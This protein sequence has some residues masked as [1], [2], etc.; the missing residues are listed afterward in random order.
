MIQLGNI[1]RWLALLV[2]VWQGSHPR[3]KLHRECRS[4]AQ[5]IM[6]QV[7]AVEA[8]FAES[9]IYRKMI[10]YMV[11]DLWLGLQV[12]RLHGV[13][14]N[15]ADR[16]RYALSAPV[17]AASLAFTPCKRWTCRPNHRSSTMYQN[18]LVH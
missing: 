3:G 16:K 12:H 9:H 5:E 4:Y 7:G 14:A 13:K 18:D 15:E 11:L 10:W 17:F 8:G 1:F 6:E 2:H